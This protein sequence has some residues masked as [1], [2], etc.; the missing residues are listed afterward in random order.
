MI[1]GFDVRNK[2]R[3]IGGMGEQLLSVVFAAVC[4]FGCFQAAVA[5]DWP[6]YMHDNHRSGVT[7][8][9]LDMPLTQGWVYNTN[10]TPQPAWAETPARAAIWQRL[11]G[12]YDS[13]VAYDLAYQVAVVGNSV[14]FGLSNGDTVLCLD[15]DDGSERWKFFTNG[16]VRFAPTVSSGKVY[17]GSEDGYVYCLNAS[18]GSPVW[19]HNASSDKRLLF[20]NSRMVSVSPVRTSV[21]VEGEKVYWAAGVFSQLGWYLCSRDANNGTGG[22]TRSPTRPAQGYLLSAGNNLFVPAGKFSPVTYSMSSGSG[23]NAIGV[24]GCYALIVDGSTFANG[25]GYGGSRSYI[26]DPGA[27]VAR[28]DGNFLVVNGGY[29]YFCND[30]QLIKLNRSTGAV[31]W[32]VASAYR[33]SLIMAGDTVF[34]GGD[35][36]VAAFSSATGKKIWSGPVNG[37]ACGLAVANGSLYVSTDSGSVHAFRDY[38]RADLNRDGSIN[39]LDLGWI[40]MEWL[41]CTHPDDKILCRDIME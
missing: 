14:Y 22:W 29:S 18:N 10:R 5:E 7:S 26:N 28:V 39:I 37:R 24:E 40:A 16:P 20:G 6:T 34:A 17:F 3:K 1:S 19:S 15:T 38:D 33:Y 4:V 36:E 9:Q 11:L 41:D 21:L 23:G 25:P 35:D 27:S 30:T 8:E 13:R 31:V 2:I 12:D 32:S